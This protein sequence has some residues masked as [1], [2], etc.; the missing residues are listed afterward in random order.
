MSYVRFKFFSRVQPF[1]HIRHNNNN[2][3]L[4]GYFPQADI[5]AEIFPVTGILR[6]ESGDRISQNIVVLG[7][8]F[9]KIPNFG[10]WS[11]LPQIQK[12][13]QQLHE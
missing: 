3:S 7:H 9:S 2:N 12:F 4:K 11:F 8:W 6:I 13:Y 5:L 10:K 1:Y